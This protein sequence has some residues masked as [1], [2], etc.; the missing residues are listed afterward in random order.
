MSQFKVD[1]MVILQNAEL[2]PELNGQDGC[3]LK[4]GIPAHSAITGKRYLAYRV[5][6]VGGAEVLA[7]PHQLRK[8]RP[9]QSTDE[10]AADMVRKV[11]KPVEQPVTEEVA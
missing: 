10:W 2:F 4:I 5:K 9:P 8:K 3:V 6:V 7:A 11:T 1:E